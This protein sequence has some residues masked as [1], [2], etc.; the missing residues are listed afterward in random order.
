MIN[1]STPFDGLAAKAK[2][3][4]ARATKRRAAAKKR[5]DDL[6]D[7]MVRNVTAK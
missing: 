4:L 1:Q 7:L 6:M 3:D 5:V 2:R